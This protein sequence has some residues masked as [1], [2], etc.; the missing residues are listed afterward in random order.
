MAH[1]PVTYLSFPTV[2]GC[3][4]HCLAYVTTCPAEVHPSAQATWRFMRLVSAFATVAANTDVAALFE[5]SDSTVRRYDKIVLSMDTPPPHLDGIRT[6]L[7][8]EKSVRKTHNY[9]TVILNGDTG[10]LLHMAEKKGSVHAP[11]HV[12][13][14]LNDFSDAFFHGSS[15]Q[16]RIFWCGLSRDGSGRWR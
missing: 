3:C 9:V 10:E 13:C 8:D 5:I 1:G 14:S 6:L 16:N 15:S 12:I 2:Q 11:E 7:F 4:P